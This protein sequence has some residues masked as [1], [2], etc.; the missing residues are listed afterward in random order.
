MPM[1]VFK[2]DVTNV[3]L[4]K[5][6][7]YAR[8]QQ[9]KLVKVYEYEEGFDFKLIVNRHGQMYWGGEQGDYELYNVH[10]LIMDLD[11]MLLPARL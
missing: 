4:E 3:K 8:H 9:F 5:I 6:V 11:T 10:N 1:N 2:V 7:E